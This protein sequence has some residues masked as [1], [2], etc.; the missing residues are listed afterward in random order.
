MIKI[1]KMLKAFAET[2]KRSFCYNVR[3]NI[4]S[5]SEVDFNVLNSITNFQFQKSSFTSHCHEFPFP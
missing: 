2:S 5:F 3:A 1:R 4:C